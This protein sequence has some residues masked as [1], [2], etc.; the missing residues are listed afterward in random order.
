[1][2]PGADTVAFK[3]ICSAPSDTPHPPT[4]IFKEMSTLG[5]ITVRL[6][7]TS[8]AARLVFSDDCFYVALCQT[9]VCKDDVKNP[10]SSK[11]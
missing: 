6:G 10:I 9:R 7:S 1:M 11:E 2:L 5:I 4:N 3:N 8:R